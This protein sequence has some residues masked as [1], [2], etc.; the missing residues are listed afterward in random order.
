MANV[1]FILRTK[2]LCEYVR[3]HISLTEMNVLSADSRIHTLVPYLKNPI[4]WPLLSITRILF[5]STVTLSK[6][7]I[8]NSK[9][10]KRSQLFA[11]FQSPSLSHTCHRA[12]PVDILNVSRSPFCSEPQLSP[13]LSAWWAIYLYRLHCFH[14]PCLARSQYNSVT[15]V[16]RRYFERMPISPHTFLQE[17]LKH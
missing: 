13:M 8:L 7:M 11:I 10:P 4:T 6:D 17:K 1:A 12:L 14:L 3:N 9:I 15:A 2:C 16:V 5:S